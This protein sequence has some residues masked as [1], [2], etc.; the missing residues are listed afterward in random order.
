[1][2][3]CIEQ[4]LIYGINIRRIHPTTK[5]NLHDFTEA[6][7]E[8]NQHT[9]RFDHRQHIFSKTETCWDVDLRRE[10]R[11][12]GSHK[13]IN[14][15]LMEICPWGTTTEMKT[16]PKPM[17][18]LMLISRNKYVMIFHLIDAKRTWA[19][20][21]Y[22]DTSNITGYKHPLNRIPSLDKEPPSPPPPPEKISPTFP[23]S[24]RFRKII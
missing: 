24:P 18:L 15:M 1:M 8:T 9:R 17:L 7:W 23:S 21:K 5:G 6:T 14:D 16:W 19:C 3:I 22:S 12:L 4:M 10:C 13:H 20:W 2:W 11:I